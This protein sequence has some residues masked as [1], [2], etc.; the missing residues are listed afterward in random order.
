PTPRPAPRAAVPPCELFPA[1]PPWPPR[2]AQAAA[3]PDSLSWTVPGA[4]AVLPLRERC[5]SFTP[6]TVHAA[7]PSC[8][9]GTGTAVDGWGASVRAAGRGEGAGH[10]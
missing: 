10:D 7:V 8:G 3:L 6:R 1:A 4:L 2:E 5:V 9:R